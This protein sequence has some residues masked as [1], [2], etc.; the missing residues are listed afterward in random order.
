VVRF[1]SVRSGLGH[2]RTDSVSGEED[3]V[4]QEPLGHQAGRVRQVLRQVQRSI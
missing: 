2:L 1:W 4:A 3:E